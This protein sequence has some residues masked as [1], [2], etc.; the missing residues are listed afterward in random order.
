M[1]T[2]PPRL[3]L[4]STSPRRRELLGLLGL[5]FTVVPSAY[6][7]PPAPSAPVDLPA[8]VTDLARNKARA[9]AQQEPNALI[10]G[11]DTLVSLS[12]E[13]IGV[14]L[15]KPADNAD[16]CR[17]LRLLAGTVH[18][19]HTGVALFHTLPDGRL[20]EP[21]CTSVRTEVRFRPLSDAMIAD[22]VATGE[23]LDKAGAYG[24][25]GFAAPFIE[26]FHGDFYNVVGLP[27]CEVGRLLER[28]GLLW[29]QH[30]QILS[31]LPDN[32]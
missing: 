1:T 16:A 8:F 5:P 13:A 29:W 30:R 23:P 17:M 21:L 14:P 26:S 2:V 31:P 15:G 6:E 22:Y 24:A 7:E 4:A 32:G 12:T 25:Q 11:A 9:V 3:I 27:L 18:T 19:V 10:L 20:T 28:S